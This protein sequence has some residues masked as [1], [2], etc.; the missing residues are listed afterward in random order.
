MVEEPDDRPSRRGGALW[1]RLAGIVF[2]LVLKGRT[3]SAPQYQRFSRMFRPLNIRDVTVSSIVSVLRWTKLCRCRCLKASNDGSCGRKSLVFYVSRSETQW[4]QVSI[5]AHRPLHSTDLCRSC[6]VADAARGEGEP[7]DCGCCSDLILK[8]D[9][10]Q[11]FGFPR[12]KKGEKGD[13]QTDQ[14]HAGTA[15]VVPY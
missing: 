3:S 6:E 11:R 8:S 12:V 15:G 1:N 9:V 4:R 2:V 14:Q 5:H 7:G 10:W 13:G